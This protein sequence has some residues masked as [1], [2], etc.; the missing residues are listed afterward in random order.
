MG[1]WKILGGIA[2]GVGAVALL[3]VAGA[4]GAVTM[5]GALVGGTIGAAVAAGSEDEKKKLREENKRV[6]ARSAVT[7]QNA[8]RQV[9]EAQEKVAEAKRETSN[10]KADFAEIKEKYD[11][12]A[13][14]L[15]QYRE[16]LKDVEAHYQLVIALTAV[17]MAAASA[18]GSV[19]ACETEEM[20]EYISGIASAKLPQKVKDRILYLHNHPPSFEEAFA[21]IAKLNKEGLPLDAFRQLI[22]DVIEAD[23]KVEEGEKIFLKKWDE[24]VVDGKI[25]VLAVKNEEQ[26]AAKSNEASNETVRVNNA[27]V[28]KPASKKP[29]ATTKKP[30]SKKKSVAKKSTTAAKMSTNKKHSDLT[31]KLVAKRPVA[32]AKK[33]MPKKHVAAVKKTAAK[34]NVTNKKAKVRVVARTNTVA[35]K[36]KAKK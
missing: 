25:K 8:M 23:G 26:T 7:T 17:G 2:T 30:T 6:V 4:V 14:V 27:A 29:V 12:T 10:I 11:K 3:P 35:N 15:E 9:A 16:S 5:T 13:A 18:D 1:F 19:D 21:E 36:G 24:A 34:K 22:V 31:K 28:V 20:D 32:S 33:T